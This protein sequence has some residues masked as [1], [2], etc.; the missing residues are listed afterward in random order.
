LVTAWRAAVIA[1]SLTLLV[2]VD[3]GNHGSKH[4][5][6]TPT[7]NTGY[8]YFK[9][10][11]HIFFP[12]ILSLSHNLS[13]SSPNFSIKPKTSSPL[14]SYFLKI[15]T[16]TMSQPS[17]PSQQTSSPNTSITKSSPSKTTTTIPNVTENTS[18]PLP[19]PSDII[20]DATPLTMIHP[21]FAS[22]LNPKPSN[23]SPS[24]KPKPKK[25]TKSA[26]TKKPK[27]QKSKSR[28][29]SNFD[30]QKLYLDDLGNAST[31]VA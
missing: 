24:P 21:S 14:Q 27:S 29:S 11:Q 25:R 10:F 22:I 9:S 6:N 16:A 5:T 20:T 17:Q 7:S 3:Q 26:T 13:N 1:V 18:V 31:N 28:Y 2:H 19:Q 15:V 8:F 30:M 4:P 23:S 12:N